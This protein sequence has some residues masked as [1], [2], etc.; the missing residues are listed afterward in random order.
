M[1]ILSN[2]TWIA[3]TVTV[4]L[5]LIVTALGRLEQARFQK[6]LHAEV[7][8]HLSQVRS[9][10]E[11]EVNANLYLTRGLVSLVK[12]YPHFTEAE[13]QIIG[14]ELLR[15]RTSVRNIGLAPNNVLNHIFPIKGNEMAIGL[16][17]RDNPDQWPPVERAM[18]SRKTVISGPLKLVEG[19]FAFLSLTPIWINTPDN[20]DGSYW[21]VASL[22]I[23][24]DTLFANAG[25]S[26]DVKSAIA[27]AIRGADGSGPEGAVFFGDSSLFERQ[28]ITM[29]VILPNGTWQLGAT[30]KG[31]WVQSSK[32]SYAVW[33]GG[34][35]FSIM[36]GFTVWGWLNAQNRQKQILMEAKQAA[37]KANRAKS[38]FL[39]RMSHELRTP[40]N[41]ILGFGQLLDL[42]MNAANDTEKQYVKHIMNSGQHLLA[43]INE[44]LDL[45]KID[46]G[47]FELKLEQVSVP[48]ILDECLVLAQPLA[49]AH[50]VA[51]SVDHPGDPKLFVWAD[52]KCLKQIVLNLVS[53]AIKY[54][55]KDGRV[56]VSYRETADEKIRLSITDTGIGIPQDK[57]EQLFQPFNRIGAE[58]SQIEGTGIGLAI[59]KNLVES[60]N[61]KIEFAST[62]GVGSEFWLEFPQATGNIDQPDLPAAQPATGITETKAMKAKILC[63]E[64]NLFNQELM[65]E[66]IS[67]FPGIELLTETTAELGLETAEKELPQLILMDINLPGMS[68]IDAIRIIR[69]HPTLAKT[70][71]IALSAASMVEDIEKSMNAGFDAYITKPFDIQEFKQTIEKALGQ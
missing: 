27:L 6:D 24:A 49:K 30:P 23:N 37:E 50:G 36:I 40:L 1:K 8:D 62:A 67:W 59:T 69:T 51:L 60:M 4:F 13:F 64:D 29:E 56:T 52:P 57:Q 11:S 55:R 12:A 54:N 45:A 63:V 3:I 33:I 44:V 65:K 34:I 10:L 53:N 15:G 35:V 38:E 28:P 20:Q 21:G 70:P 16:V 18:L 22:V 9:R 47:K 25:I 7:V 31:G 58:N 26:D 41:A 19:N 43:L 14:A 5:L 42:G 48:D 66:I 2:S 71:V 68:G 32:F 39:S 17:Y 61:G 46:A